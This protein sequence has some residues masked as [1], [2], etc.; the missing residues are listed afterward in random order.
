MNLS[1]QKFKHRVLTA[2][3][4]APIVIL[5]IFLLPPFIFAFAITLCLAIIGWEWC[6]LTGLSILADQIVFIFALLFSFF[7]AYTFLN[8]VV[9]ILAIIWWIVAIFLIARYPASKEI[10]SK[11]KII[12]SIVGLL[13]LVP[14]AVAIINVHELGPQYLIYGF[15]IVWSTDTGAFFVG[16][17][18]GRHKLAPQVSPGKTIE[19]VFGGLCLALIIGILGAWVLRIPFHLW[20]W[21]ILLIVC[22]SLASVVGDLFESM[23]K[24]HA[25]VKDSGNWLPGHGGLLDRIDSLTCAMPVFALGMI[26]LGL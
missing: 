22:V 8:F 23:I 25:G 5:A 26:W 24:R 18:F 13:I 20:P 19:G 16:Q 6:R 7:I 3:I 21:L 14:G 15:I 4:L 17:R 11:S 9:L 12:F 2:S 10:L 1:S